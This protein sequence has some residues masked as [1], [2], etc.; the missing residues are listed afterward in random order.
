MKRASEILNPDSL[1]RM[2]TIIKDE[3]Q[4]GIFFV[5]S[6]SFFFAL[7]LFLFKTFL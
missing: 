4:K 5:F 1:H 2:M 3:T 6:L 7:F